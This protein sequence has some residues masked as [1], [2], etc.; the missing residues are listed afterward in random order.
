MT[1]P[2][3]RFMKSACRSQS[4][5][6][7]LPDSPY[8]LAYQKGSITRRWDQFISPDREGAMVA[9]WSNHDPSRQEQLFGDDAIGVN[10]SRCLE[11]T[12][13]FLADID[14]EQSDSGEI[15]VH[16]ELLNGASEIFAGTVSEIHADENFVLAAK[17]GVF[18]RFPGE[19][20]FSSCASFP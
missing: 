12:G 2:V 9:A 14:A 15:L 1:R 11:C 16:S 19:N 3:Q 8:P 20:R 13:L 7:L 6:S 18:Q 10:E 17:S 4:A 5:G